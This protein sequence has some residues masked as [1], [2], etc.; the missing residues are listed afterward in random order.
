MASKNGG[1]SSLDL[2][3][4][5]RMT[6]RYLD[7]S[8][9]ELPFHQSLLSRAA[10][11][12]VGERQVKSSFVFLVKR[13]DQTKLFTALKDAQG[14]LSVLGPKWSNYK[15][16]F[17]TSKDVQNNIKENAAKERREHDWKTFSYNFTLEKYIN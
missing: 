6:C 10:L 8:P 3:P 12:T 2:F 9:F 15:G 16:V 1:I 17:A 13:K 4:A 14:D 7:S 5:F 11:E